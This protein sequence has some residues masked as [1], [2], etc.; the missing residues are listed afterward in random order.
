MKKKYVAYIL[1]ILAVIPLISS[2]ALLRYSPESTF[3]RSTSGRS[4]GIFI[5]DLNNDGKE[6]LI[7]QPRLPHSS[8]VYAMR[9]TS[10]GRYETFSLF[11]CPL[12]DIP[13]IAVGDT[14]NDDLRN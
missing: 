3:A 6:E 5:E 11:R 8:N 13:L 7:T 2:I 4:S 9:S 12:T 1:I 14:D 10:P